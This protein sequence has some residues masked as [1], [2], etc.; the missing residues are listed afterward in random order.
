MV[1]NFF[2]WSS[3]FDVFCPHRILDVRCSAIGGAKFN[4]PNRDVELSGFHFRSLEA[5]EDTPVA[6]E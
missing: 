1:E 4:Q 6:V 3:S 5:K 2:F